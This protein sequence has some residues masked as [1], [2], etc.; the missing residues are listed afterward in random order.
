MTSRAEILGTQ[1][2][3]EE[4]VVR[5]DTLVSSIFIAPQNPTYKPSPSSFRKQQQK[6]SSNSSLSKHF[7]LEVVL[8]NTEICVF[9]VYSEKTFQGPKILTLILPTCHKENI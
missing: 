8:L 6:F 7:F 1:D 4:A 9:C 3:P 5:L 2:A